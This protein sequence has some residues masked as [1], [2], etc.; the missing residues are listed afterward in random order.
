MNLLSYYQHLRVILSFLIILAIANT[1]CNKDDELDPL[2]IPEGNTGINPEDRLPQIV[3]NSQ[4]NAIVD[5]PKVDAQMTILENDNIT[6][7]GK[8]GIEFR[9]AS[10]QWF[11]KKSYGVETRDAA[12][13]DLDVALLG[14]PEEEDWVLYAPYTDKSLLRNVLIYDLSNDIDR[15][16]S[17]TVL[18]ELTVNN[19]KQGIYVLMEKLKRDALRININ[20]LKEEENSGEDLTGGY[21]LKIDKTAGNNFGATP[22][23]LDYSDFNSFVSNHSPRHALTGQSIKF[24]YHYPDPDI[25]SPQ[26]KE[27]IQSY[28]A[29]FENALASDD[30]TDASK[31]YA[32]YIDVPSFI[33]FFLMN[34][35]THNVDG[36]RLSSFMHKDKG[37]KLIMGPIWDFNLGFGNADYC[38][39]SNTNTWAYK[40][41]ERCPEDFWQVPF[42]WERLM[43]DPNFVAQVK[44]RWTTLRGGAFSEGSI[45]TKL[46]EYTTALEKSGAINSNFSIWQILGQYVWP[47]N[48]IGNSHGAE[49]NYLEGWIEG[50]LNWMDKAIND[51]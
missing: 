34:E 1:S 25:I 41:N 51:L 9:G 11:P 47:N 31:G 3:I 2:D 20:K 18:V 7:N 12:N 19:N 50:R 39:G 5:E 21:I 8:I 33:D 27:Y 29:D 14:L 4:G 35:L 22:S 45:L 10:S 28:M 44:N 6:F 15:Y 17:R 32:A 37:G 48:F 13:E 42:W 36:Y 23:E 26:Q 30:F 49:I 24:L 46:D 43:E 40:F 38:G 16:A